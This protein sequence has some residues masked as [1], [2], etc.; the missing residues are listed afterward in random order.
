MPCGVWTWPGGADQ[1]E[2]EAFLRSLPGSPSWVAADGSGAIKNAVAAVWPHAVFYACERHLSRL[3]DEALSHDGI[4]AGHALHTLWESAQWSTAHLAA[5]EVAPS[6]E[7]ASA[8]RKWV[9][10]KRPLITSQI[11]LRQPD[12]LGARAPSRRA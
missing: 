11:G 12:D 5:F 4:Y 8:M 2:W 10:R 1:V 3:G 9:I 6:Q 7:T